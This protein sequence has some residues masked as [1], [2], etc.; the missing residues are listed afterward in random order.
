MI[1]YLC[2]I[3]KATINKTSTSFK[4]QTYNDGS[5]YD[6]RMEEQKKHRKGTY[7]YADGDKYVG[8]WIDDN[9]A[10]QGVYIWASGDAYEKKCSQM[11]FHK[12]L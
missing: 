12:S 5:R 10:G 6:G 9:I 1:V 8:D 7:Y 3:K 11:S 2:S 4:V